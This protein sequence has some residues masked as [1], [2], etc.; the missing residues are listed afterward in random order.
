MV[1]IPSGWGLCFT[2]SRRCSLWLALNLG[3]V[4]PLFK[5]RRVTYFNNQTPGH[6]FPCYMKKI[7]VKTAHS[8]L[9]RGVKGKQRDVN[10]PAN[11]P[12][13]RPPCSRAK[14]L[15]HPP[16]PMEM[17]ESFTLGSKKLGL[18][19]RLEAMLGTVC[20]CF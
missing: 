7:M 16:P 5:Y 2:V 13:T 17:L 18:F 11:P 19:P 1:L 12:A 14:L 3:K 4:I 9:Q 6:S 15:L 8:Q 20:F 10:P